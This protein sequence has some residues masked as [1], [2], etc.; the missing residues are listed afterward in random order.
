MNKEYAP[1]FQQEERIVPH[2]WFIEMFHKSDNNSENLTEILKEMYK[3]ERTPQ[4]MDVLNTRKAKFKYVTRVNF[5]DAALYIL[6]KVRRYKMW[7]EKKYNEP[8]FGP[9]LYKCYK[10]PENK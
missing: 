5:K 2:P 10:K 1:V 3:T 7:Y 4:I 9:E 6:W 8:L